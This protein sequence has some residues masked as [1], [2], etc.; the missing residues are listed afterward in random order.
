MATEMILSYLIDPQDSPYRLKADRRTASGC[1][2]PTLA[3]LTHFRHEGGRT[4]IGIMTM[5]LLISLCG[6]ICTL[7]L[8]E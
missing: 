6:L 8:T 4:W 5:F 7:K 1:S 2:G 3:Q